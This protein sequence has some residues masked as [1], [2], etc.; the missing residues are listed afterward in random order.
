MRSASNCSEDLNQQI[1][2]NCD[3]MKNLAQ[4]I[5]QSSQ[6]VLDS[7]NYQSNFKLHNQ[8][9]APDSMYTESPLLLSKRLHKE[10]E[11]ATAHFKPS[12]TKRGPNPQIDEYGYMPE[13][14]GVSEIKAI[15][16]T[17][18]SH[19][20]S[21]NQILT[22]NIQRGF[23]NTNLLLSDSKPRLK[24]VRG[25]ARRTD[26]KREGMAESELV[27]NRGVELFKKQKS[28]QKTGSAL[29]SRREEGE[30]M[31][32][33]QVV[34]GGGFENGYDA[35]DIEEFEIQDLN[36]HAGD[37]GLPIKAT[38]SLRIVGVMMMQNF[39]NF[40]MVINKMTSNMKILGF[41]ERALFTENVK[42]IFK[43]QK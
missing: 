36:L 39:L 26:F 25:S 41:R 43:T 7:V 27:D 34:N 5:N 24:K 17:D 29:Q 9:G 30:K 12:T 21:L 31:G 6:K 28:E 1:V 22:E 33:I 13:N 11:F 8:I 2:F 14:K 16:E 38:G 42:R 37:R 35:R 19:D 20:A 23:E 40:E 32:R 4:L 10:N 18:V 15:H 3:K